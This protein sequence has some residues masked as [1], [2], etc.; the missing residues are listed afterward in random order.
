MRLPATASVLIACALLGTAP[1]ASA[2]DVQRGRSLYELRCGG[3]HAVSVHGRAKREARD[4]GDVRHWV[5]RWGDYLH[6]QWGEEEV[7]D[8]AA[9]LDATYYHFSCD[10]PPCRVGLAGPGGPR[11]ARASTTRGREPCSSPPRSA[12]G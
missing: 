10:K 6:L 8:V 11:G 9:Y 3:C 1:F 2:A 7:D 5:K 4:P 12:T